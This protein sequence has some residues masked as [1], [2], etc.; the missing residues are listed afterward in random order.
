MCGG[1]MTGGRGEGGEQRIGAAWYLLGAPTTS[2][3]PFPTLSMRI[4]PV[5]EDLGPML[6]AV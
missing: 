4:I 6:L 2:V 5:L 3:S 1:K